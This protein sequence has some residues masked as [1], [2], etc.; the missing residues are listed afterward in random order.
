MPLTQEL[1]D[2][3]QQRFGIYCTPCH[4]KIG[5]GNG[6]VVQRGFTKPRS[7]HDLELRSKPVGYYYE[8][9]TK[10]FGRM[11]DYAAQIQPAD[12]WAI[13]AYIRALQLSQ[14]AEFASLPEVDRKAVTASAN[15]HKTANDGQQG[16]EHH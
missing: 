14:S 6:M 4:D 13:V 5:T 2:R 1:L 15:A 3:G 12:R 16:G 8:V 10:G 7:Y 11:S 9:I